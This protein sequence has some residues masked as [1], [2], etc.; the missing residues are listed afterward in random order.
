MSVG[1][2]RC[3]STAEHWRSASAG[4]ER[5]RRP[6]APLRPSARCLMSTNPVS[7]PDGYLCEAGNLD[8]RLPQY[9]DMPSSLVRGD[10]RMKPP[11][12]SD[13]KPQYVHHLAPKAEVSQA[14]PEHKGRSAWLWEGG[15]RVSSSEKCW[16]VNR[17]EAEVCE[18]DREP[19]HLPA[20]PPAAG[21][22]SPGLLLSVF[23]TPP[24]SPCTPP[25][26]PSPSVAPSPSQFPPP[27]ST[28]C[29]VAMGAV[30][31]SPSGVTE[32]STVQPARMKPLVV[33][34]YSPSSSSSPPEILSEMPDVLAS[35]CL[36]WSSVRLRGSRS[37]LQVFGSGG[38]RSVCSR[39]W[40]A[41]QGR[42]SCLE[43]GYSRSDAPPS[44]LLA[45]ALM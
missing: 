19:G 22:N 45:E 35:E 17:L 15:G 42:A 8:S 23:L 43:L 2:G 11:S 14:G 25:P 33:F 4:L 6:L 28:A 12:R 26:L 10:Q 5:P 34:L 1:E 3:C 39:G 41:Q 24:S 36:C 29:S 30:C 7:S 13:V 9:R 27:A 44:L 18:A 38:W 32:S 21:W 37:E 31:G 20:P 40:G 16:F